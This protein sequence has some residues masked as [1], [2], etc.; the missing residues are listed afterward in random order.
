MTT[1]RWLVALALMGSLSGCWHQ[2]TSLDRYLQGQLQADRG[3]LDSALDSLSKAI[4]KNPQLGLAYVARGEVY[5]KKGDYE[6]AAKD[7]EHATKIEPFNFNANY[8]FGLMCQYLKRFADS[9]KA[10][11]KAVEIRPLDPDAN[12]NLA[13]VY[14]Q[15]GEPL[16]GL[17]YAQRAVNGNPDSP[18]TRANLGILYARLNQTDMAIDELKKAIEYNSKQPEVYLNLAQEYFKQQKY[19]QARNVLNTA[20]DLAPSPVVSERLGVTY[21]KLHQ[22]DKA[23]E[24]FNDS[25]RQNANY[26]QALNGLGVIAMSQSLAANPPDISLAREA[27]G[28][29]DRSLKIE[30]NQPVIQQLANKYAGTK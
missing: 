10:Y 1:I 3:E 16:R 5:K 18:N 12:M 6:Q 11:Q 22:P 9:V 17:S 20:K 24:A 28:Y 21:Y 2:P 26:F 25:L 4:E 8:Q 30:P 13:M 27:L 23:R 19:E 14:V 7:F 29:W 15:L